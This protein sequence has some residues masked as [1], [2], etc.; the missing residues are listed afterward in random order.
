MNHMV[1]SCAILI[2]ITQEQGRRELAKGALS[3]AGGWFGTAITHSLV[4][5]PGSTYSYQ[6]S[7]LKVILKSWENFKIVDIWE[8]KCKMVEGRIP[9]MGLKACWE[10]MPRKRMVSL[11]TKKSFFLPLVNVPRYHSL[12][13]QQNLLSLFSI[14]ASSCHESRSMNSSCQLSDDGELEVVA[15]TW[16]TV[17]HRLLIGFHSM[18][19][20]RITY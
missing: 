1:Q 15:M 12:F 20:D 14:L 18:Q 16:V 10:Q 6:S 7:F 3:V 17:T 2:G 19:T 4:L 11:V 9:V 8:K 13:N 5:S